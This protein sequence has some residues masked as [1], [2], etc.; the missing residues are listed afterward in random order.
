M[1]QIMSK[2]ADAP[3]AHSPIDK[4]NEIIIGDI[5]PQHTQPKHLMWINYN[6]NDGIMME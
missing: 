6:N 1:L 2:N 4:P 5:G 3:I